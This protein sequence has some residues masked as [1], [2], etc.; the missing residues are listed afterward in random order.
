MAIA[1]TNSVKTSP[2]LP[3]RFAMRRIGR[4]V[5][6]SIG[7]KIRGGSTWMEPTENTLYRILGGLVQNLDT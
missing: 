5:T 2:G 4:E 6:S 1:L 3:I 7:A